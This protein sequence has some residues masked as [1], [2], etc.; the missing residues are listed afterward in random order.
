[1]YTVLFGEIKKK[2]LSTKLPSYRGK[3]STFDPIHP[4]SRYAWCTYFA[5]QV[6]M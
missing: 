2:K 3:T 5:V 4:V 6:I 1:M